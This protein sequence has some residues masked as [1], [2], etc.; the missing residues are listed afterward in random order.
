MAWVHTRLG[1]SDEK[2]NCTIFD[3]NAVDLSGISLV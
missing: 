1:E 3:S 2:D